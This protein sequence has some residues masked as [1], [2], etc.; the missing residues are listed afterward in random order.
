MQYSFIL[1]FYA[2]LRCVGGRSP[3]RPLADEVP[4]LAPDHPAVHALAVDDLR[5]APGPEP[6]LGS[7][8]VPKQILGKNH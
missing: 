1:F 3:V 6:E 7:T 4:D 5:A 2:S 8:R